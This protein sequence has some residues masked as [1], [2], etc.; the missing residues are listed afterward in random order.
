MHIARLVLFQFA[1][2]LRSCVVVL[3]LWSNERK[4]GFVGRDKD[5]QLSRFFG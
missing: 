4:L 5:S 2:L 1:A 3:A